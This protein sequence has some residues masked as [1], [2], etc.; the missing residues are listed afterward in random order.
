MIQYVEMGWVV[1]S[2]V[3][4]LVQRKEKG[5]S[6]NGGSTRR[7]Q[8]KMGLYR[9]LHVNEFCDCRQAWRQCRHFGVVIA[10]VAVI[11]F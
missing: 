11:E 5:G 6:I 3:G 4:C 10:A 7:E 8:E 2:K 9:R 1:R